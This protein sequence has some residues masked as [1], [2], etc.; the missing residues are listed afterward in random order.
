MQERRACYDGKFENHK[1]GYSVNIK[2]PYT[3]NLTNEN[4]GTNVFFKSD[5]KYVKWH[6]SK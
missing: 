6:D 4:S 3:T 2:L 1:I 5:N